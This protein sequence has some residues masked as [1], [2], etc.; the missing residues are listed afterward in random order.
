MEEAV[1]ERIQ[2]LMPIK[3]ARRR[4]EVELTKS[5]W[6]SHKLTI[7]SESWGLGIRI[8]ALGMGPFALATS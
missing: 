7:P 4:R 5:R 8:P 6:S 2:Q 1:L 3:I